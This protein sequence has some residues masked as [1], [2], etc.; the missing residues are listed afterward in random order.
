MLL[1]K[2]KNSRYRDVIL[3]SLWTILGLGLRWLNLS[4]KPPW[5]DEFA[6][7]VFSLGNSFKTVPLDQIISANDLLQPLIVNPQHGMGQA[8]NSLIREDHHPPIYFALANLW[9]RLFSEPEGLVNLEVMRSLPALCGVLSIP[10]IY[11]L[12]KLTF[13]SSTIA[14]LTAIMMA[15]SPYGVFISQEARHYTM[16]VL[17]VIASLGCL[18]AAAKNLFNRRSLPR[19]ISLLW[20]VINTLGMGIHYFFILTLV[21]EILVLIYLGWQARKNLGSIGKFFAQGWGILLAILGT[22]AGGLVWLQLW[23]YS[24]DDQ[25]TEWL[26]SGDRSLL[27]FINPL[28]QSAATWVTMVYLLPIEGPNLG[29]MIIFIIIMTLSLFG[30]LAPLLYRGIKEGLHN[31]ETTQGISVIGGFAIASISIFFAITYFLGMDITRGARYNFVY[32]P[33][34]ILMV[35][36]S[37]SYFWKKSIPINSP[38][39]QGFNWQYIKLFC[40]GK[41]AVVIVLILGLLSGLTVA[42]NLGYQKYYR[43]DML[44]PIIQNNSTKP[45]IIATTHNTLVQTGEMM[46]IAWDWQRHYN[47]SPPQYLLAHQQQ[48][49][50]QGDNCAASKTLREQIEKRSQPL[51]LWLINF[52]APIKL[53]NCTAA[54]VEKVDA[55]WVNGYGYKLYK[56]NQKS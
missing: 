53:R 50:C 30:W 11:Y 27:D 52:H 54:K 12:A 56:C 44:I 29:V 39:P 48:R 33:A 2:L 6:T 1:S 38:V 7:L 37:L 23:L 26:K 20:I 47:T 43:P 4:G 40:Q 32:F 8:I 3:L 25:M 9:G 16:A 14:H 10:A 55:L 45:V 41:K 34:V 31:P 42:T 17:L 5:T 19:K 24:R 36:V 21:A 15:V 28:F 51:D 18:I 13:A 49:E 46:G 22:G 35:G